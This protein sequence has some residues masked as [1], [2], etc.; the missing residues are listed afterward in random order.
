MYG[1]LEGSEKQNLYPENGGP[2]GL[3]LSGC[4]RKEGLEER[5]MGVVMAAGKGVRRDHAYVSVLVCVCAGGLGNGLPLLLLKE[6]TANDFISGPRNY[7]K[8]NMTV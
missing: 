5:K 7:E 8:L 1:T 2:F 6:Q 3:V 4:P